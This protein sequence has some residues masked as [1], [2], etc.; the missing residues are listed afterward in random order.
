MMK[1]MKLQITVWMLSLLAA[2]LLAPRVSAR[3]CEAW[4][5]QSIPTDMPDLR[6]VPGVLSTGEQ[7]ISVEF[8]MDN[9]KSTQ[10][11]LQLSCD[12]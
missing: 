3:R 7:L 2:N 10:W 1:T 6:I 11:K 8:E 5:V 4:L 12:V 9:K